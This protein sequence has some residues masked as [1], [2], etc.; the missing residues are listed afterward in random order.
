MARSSSPDP[1]LA[2]ETVPG[3]LAGHE[4]EV[5]LDIADRAILD[6][7]GARPRTPVDDRT[8]PSALQRLAASFVTL[9]VHGELNGCIGTIE[10][11]EPLAGSVARH[12]WAAAF[13]DPRLPPLRRVDYPHLT[14]AISV[15]S[16]VDPLAARSRE[17][18]RDALR[19]GVDGLVLEAAGRRAVFLPSV[20]S[21][22]ATP[23][24]FVAELFAK[25]G[26]DRRYWAPDVRAATFTV[27]HVRSED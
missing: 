2:A 5:L 12:A 25:A 8:V 9:H 14:I 24:R 21:S 11:V 10:P 26:L 17:E 27:E 23:D 18:L 19:P 1:A 16:P 6:G 22:L 4:R 15:L 7:L 3:P 13:D 20:W